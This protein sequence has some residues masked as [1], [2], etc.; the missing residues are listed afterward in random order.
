[1][2]K[3]KLVIEEL[4]VESFE[5][6]GE[7]SGLGTV[8]ANSGDSTCDDR[9]CECTGETEWNVSCGSCLTP[10]NTCDAGCGTQHNCPTNVAY[11]GC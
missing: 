4:A 1:M 9:I 11:P 2:A 8:L 3:L 5:A 7:K 6:L 10:E